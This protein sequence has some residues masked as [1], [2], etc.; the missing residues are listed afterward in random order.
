MKF[1]VTKKGTGWQSLETEEDER[2]D[3]PLVAV[4]SRDTHAAPT[5]EVPRTSKKMATRW[6]SGRRKKGSSRERKKYA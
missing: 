5:S 2:G 6:G 3:G 1:D 4:R